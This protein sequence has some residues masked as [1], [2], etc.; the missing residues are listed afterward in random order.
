MVALE[1][2][3]GFLKRARRRRRIETNHSGDVVAEVILERILIE[4]KPLRRLVAQHFEKAPG[5]SAHTG[6]NTRSGAQLQINCKNCPANTTLMHVI[7]FYDQIVNVSA[8][9]AEILD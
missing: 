5:S 6:V 3:L 1:A 8:A 9:G 4:V 2:C 7:L